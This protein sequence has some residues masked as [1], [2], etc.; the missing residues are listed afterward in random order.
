MFDSPTLQPSWTL[1]SD[2]A[3]IGTRFEVD[4]D[5]RRGAASR[6]VAASLQAP[7]YLVLQGHLTA[8]GGRLPGLHRCMVLWRSLSRTLWRPKLH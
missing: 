6:I 7:L 5:S 2:G 4:G 1:D 3:C 8:H